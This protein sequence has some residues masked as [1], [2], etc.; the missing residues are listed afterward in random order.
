MGNIKLNFLHICDQVL[1][2]EGKT[3]II[4]IF[5]IIRAV[6][7]PAIHPR[8]A[9]ITNIS[10]D[11]GLFE[12]K[13]EIMSPNNELIAG[14]SGRAEIKSDGANNFISNFINLKFP[15]E[16]KYWIR[17]RVGEITLTQKDEYFILVKKNT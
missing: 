4:N 11:A 9:I 16:G 6:G 1:I 12:E 10:G 8:F 13:I 2:S 5:N 7:F 15:V 17:I 14:V 3:S